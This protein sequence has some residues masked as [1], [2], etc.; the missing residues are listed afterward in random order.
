MPE[1][2]SMRRAPLMAQFANCGALV[3]S[4]VRERR[5]VSNL[6]TTDSCKDT[7]SFSGPIGLYAKGD[8]KPGFPPPSGL[9]PL[10]AVGAAPGLEAGSPMSFFMRSVIS[11][12]APATPSTVFLIPSTVLAKFS[13][14]FFSSSSS[15]SSSS[16]TSSSSPSA[17]PSTSSTNPEPKMPAGKAKSP[18]PKK[19]TMEPNTLPTLVV[20]VT[21][22]YPTVVKAVTDHHM[23]AG[24]D[25]KSS[26]VPDSM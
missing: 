6:R 25:E 15:S 2:T 11:F 1:E 12:W 14:F 4:A 24:T 16:P 18:T 8:G 17:S 3:S 13:I 7:K 21:S 26:L 23:A 22:P 5:I 10:A 9:G 19:A 20:G